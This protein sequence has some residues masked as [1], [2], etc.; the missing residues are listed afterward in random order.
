V[1]TYQ[2][3]RRSLLKM[4][5]A[6]PLFATL[7]ARKLSAAVTGVASKAAASDASAEV[8]TRLGVRP[9]INARGTWTYLTGSLELPEVRKAAELASHHFVD[10]FELQRAAGKR[11]AELSGAEDGMI[12][13][14]SA[15]AM[16]SA[17]AACMAGTDQKNIWQLPDTTGLKDEVIMLGGRISFDSAIRL[18]GAKLLLAGDVDALTKAIN[19]KTAMVYTAWHD[20]TRLAPAIKVTKAAGV[21]ILIDDAAGIPPFENVTRFAKMSADM[22]CF[23]GGKGLGG[24]QSSGLLFG[25]HDL[26][27]AARANSAPWE[28]SICRS[29]KVG[30]EEIIGVLAALEYWSKADL[31][32][33][34]L[35]WKARVERAQKLIDTVPGVT[36]SITIPTGGNSYPTLS[37]TWDE[38]K[39]G[40]TVDQCAEQMRAGEPRIEVL[41]NNNPS[42]LTTVHEGMPTSVPRAPRANRIS[43][44]SMTLQPGEDLIVGNRLRQVLEDARKK[45]GA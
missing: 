11:L 34:N 15:G 22:Y 25:R 44:I 10:M 43:I 6:A 45:S 29:M 13:T 1:R 14:G 18:C 8:Y 7:G 21:P 30:K 40:L 26:M 27:E 41:T 23:S 32:A 5:V 42:L 38:A 17:T 39:F 3:D 35:E 12:T 19:P 2:D 16:A 24:P 4:L 36:T 9:L 28:G 37:V 31:N 33:L 20:E